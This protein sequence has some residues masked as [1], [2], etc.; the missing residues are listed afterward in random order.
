MSPSHGAAGRVPSPGACIE[1]RQFIAAK[2]PFRRGSVLCVTQFVSFVPFVV[3]A[4]QIPEPRS[5][6]IPRSLQSTT[7]PSGSE[8]NRALPFVFDSD[9][10]TDA[11]GKGSRPGSS[12]FLTVA[13]LSVSE[14]TGAEAQ[15]SHRRRLPWQHDRNILKQRCLNRV[16]ENSELDTESSC[17]VS[18]FSAVTFSNASGS[19]FETSPA[20][21]SSAHASPDSTRSP[22]GRPHPGPGTS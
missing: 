22:E 2:H 14:E 17:T 18:T 8:S 11:W 5:T 6:R 4:H 10:D 19:S 3:Q 13:S 12:S 1:D 16:R 20:S 15:A 9:A 21:P 7:S